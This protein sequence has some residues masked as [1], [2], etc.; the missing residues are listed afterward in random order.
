M[1]SNAVVAFAYTTSIPMEGGL[2]I[3]MGEHDDV[4]EANLRSYPRLMAN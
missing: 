3:D 2:T 1:L 4:E